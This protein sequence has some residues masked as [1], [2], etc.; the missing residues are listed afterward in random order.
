MIRASLLVLLFVSLV[1]RCWAQSEP[2]ALPSVTFTKEFPG[3]QPAYVSLTVRESGESLY[4][5]DPDETPVQFQLSP[6]SS[7]QIFALARKMDLFRGASLESNR[8]VAQMGKKTFAFEGGS[9]R[10]AASFNHTENTDA[11][12]LAS[13]FERLSQTRQHLDKLEYLLRFDRL[14]I[15]KELLQV[16]IDLNQDRLL[17]PALLLPV[18]E[19]IQG[20]R[21]L[22]NVAQGRAAQIVARLRTSQP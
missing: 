5:T 16:E 8:K 17:E 20:N 3:S 9:E 13:L 14:G 21:S 18:L 19:K 2:A 15:V 4:R 7:Q 10:T 22:V 1:P 11:L 6:D 12:A